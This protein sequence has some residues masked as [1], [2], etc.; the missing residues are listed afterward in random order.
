MTKNM[1]VELASQGWEVGSHTRTHPN[2]TELSN[3][4]IT[5]ELSQSKSCLERI[6]PGVSSLAYPFGAC[7]ARVRALASRHYKFAR[8]VSCYPPLRLNRVPSLN[9]LQLSAM[10]T[11]DH[12]FSLPLRLIN[13]IVYSKIVGLGPQ[14]RT[15]ITTRYGFASSARKGLEARFVKKWIRNLRNDQWLILCF[16][17]ISNQKPSTSYTISQTE[18]R[19][20]VKVISGG[21]EIVT[22]KDAAKRIM[23]AG[24]QNRSG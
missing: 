21:P 6:A 1:L 13:D 11:Y 18:F 12:P 10:S 15:G 2:L 23:S 17:D 20:I 24:T 16:H 3:K 9:T 8:T 7:D 14:K 4:E 22:L 19:E 5:A